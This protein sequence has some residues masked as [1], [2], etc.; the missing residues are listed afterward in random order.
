MD[1]LPRIALLGTFVGRGRERQVGE[2]CAAQGAFYTLAAPATGTAAS[3][4]LQVLGIGETSRTLTLSLVPAPLIPRLRQELRDRLFMTQPG[5]GILFTVPLSGINARSARW[6]SQGMD[7]KPVE[8]LALTNRGCSD[9]V[10][11]AA[12]LAGATGGTLLHTR[13]LGGQE[14]DRFLGI[15][16]QKEKELVAILAK[17]EYKVPI[18]Q[19]IA[20]KAGLQTPAETVVL[21]LPVDSMEGLR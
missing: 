10:L 12:R 16:L 1:N 17:G 2:I 11:A 5:Q 15:Q 9:E 13:M 6:L 20:D 3:E 19:T 14:A 21:S 4:V 7:G 18:M 8:I